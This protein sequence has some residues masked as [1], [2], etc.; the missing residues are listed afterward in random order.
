VWYGESISDTHKSVIAEGQLYGT[1]L[2]GVESYTISSV[3]NED[4][5]GNYRRYKYD[6]VSL[7][8]LPDDWVDETA[9]NIEGNEDK[10]IGSDHSRDLSPGLRGLTV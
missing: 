10:R 9:T 6:V 4:E 1:I 8:E 3:L 7:E 5:T 2:D